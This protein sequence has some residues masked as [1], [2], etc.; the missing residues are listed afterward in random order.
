MHMTAEILASLRSRMSPYTGV[1]VIN[2][3]EFGQLL[4]EIDRLGKE[5]ETEK[6]HWIEDDRDLNALID[7][8]DK[9]Q[10]ENQAL[11]QALELIAMP[12]RPDGTYNRCREACEQ[13]AREALA[14][15]RAGAGE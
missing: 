3:T 1:V 7:T 6:R 14:H 15:P 9:L 8:R 10:Q 11:R 12:K 5:L 13:L 2:N 4:D